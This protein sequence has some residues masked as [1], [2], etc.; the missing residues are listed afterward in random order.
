MV[1][2]ELLRF[3]T[4]IREAHP[5]NQK[6]YMEGQCYNFALIIRTIR[7]EAVIHYSHLE[8]HVYTE[9]NG[10]LYDIRGAL[11][12][13]AERYTNIPVLDHRCGDKPHRWGRRDKRTLK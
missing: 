9:V 1:D 8:G 7:P 10:R 3:I 11:P 4:A 2:H 5:D 6:L 13:P 12:L